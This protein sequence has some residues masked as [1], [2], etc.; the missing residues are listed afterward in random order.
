MKTLVKTLIITLLLLCPLSALTYGQDGDDTAPPPDFPAQELRFQNL[1]I[2]D[3][4][5]QISVFAIVQDKRG[6]M[7]FGT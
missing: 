2:E 3:G 6:F 1:T 7:W 4:L 5:S